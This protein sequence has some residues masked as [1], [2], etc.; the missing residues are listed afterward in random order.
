MLVVY[1]CNAKS[2]V[3]GIRD[4]TVVLESIRLKDQFITMNK[5]LVNVNKWGSSTAS[6]SVSDSIIHLK[7]T[8]YYWEL[9]S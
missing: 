6:I 7:M 9:Q 8:V 1:T 2:L 5:H 4:S 3:R